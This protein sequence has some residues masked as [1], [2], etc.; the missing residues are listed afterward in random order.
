MY[1]AGGYR[2]LWDY[3]T[4]VVVQS[5]GEEVDRFKA[6]LVLASGEVIAFPSDRELENRIFSWLDGNVGKVEQKEKD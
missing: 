5:A 1:A 3:A 2:F 4:D 6:G